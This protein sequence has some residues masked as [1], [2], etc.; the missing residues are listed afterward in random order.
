MTGR[1]TYWKPAD[2]MVEEHDRTLRGWGQYFSLGAVSRAY[3][4]VDNHA[5]HRLR[6]WLNGRRALS[7]NDAVE[8]GMNHNRHKWTQIPAGLGAKGSIH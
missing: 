5:R 6:Q 8:M 2:L 3:R 1:G 4:T 7:R